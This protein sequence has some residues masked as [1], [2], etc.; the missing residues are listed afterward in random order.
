VRYNNINN[1]PM[2][3]IEEIISPMESI[4]EII[5]LMESIVEIISPME[6][7]V[8][9]MSPM[10]SIVEIISLIIYGVNN[11]NIPNGFDCR[12]KNSVKSI[13]EIISPLSQ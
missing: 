12:N 8:K 6:S 7:I 2:E 3:S 11:R 4:V 10:E 13:V 1:I 5:S 9:I